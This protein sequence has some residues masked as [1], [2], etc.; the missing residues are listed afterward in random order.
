M[1][2][3]TAT[4]RPCEEQLSGAYASRNEVDN[5]GK[6][7]RPM[8]QAITGQDAPFHDRNFVC[9]DAFLFT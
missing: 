2:H 7:T 6:A 8:T 1:I 4:I 5:A 9:T 3:Q